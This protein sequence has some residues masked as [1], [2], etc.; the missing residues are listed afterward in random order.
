MEIEPALPTQSINPNRRHEPKHFCGGTRGAR[1]GCSAAWGWV[2]QARS[3]SGHRR[4]AWTIKM[5]ATRTTRT[6]T[7]LCDFETLAFSFL[8]RSIIYQHSATPFDLRS[9]LP[10]PC[11]V[12]AVARQLCKLGDNNYLQWNSTLKRRHP[13]HNTNDTCTL[14]LCYRCQ[15]MFT[16]TRG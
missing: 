8:A 11:R 9:R 12:S 10:F 13:T 16:C 5:A 7:G 2:D 4:L 14:H 6:S 15:S 1:W 3:F